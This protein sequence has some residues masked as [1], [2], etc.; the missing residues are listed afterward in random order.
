M[1]N[2]EVNY[3][4]TTEGRAPQLVLYVDGIHDVGRVLATLARGNVE[5]SSQAHEAA[6]ELRR[7][8]EGRATLTY[9]ES[10]GGPT[11]G[12]DPNVKCPECGHEQYVDLDYVTTPFNCPYCPYGQLEAVA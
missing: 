12:H 11:L 4:Q 3:T 10:H 1:I 9:L 8:K 5:H 2:H 7:S 6:T